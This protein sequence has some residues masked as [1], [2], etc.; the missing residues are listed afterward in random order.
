MS[1][2]A[3]DRPLEPATLDAQIAQADDLVVVDPARAEALA[4]AAAAQAERLHLPLQ[5][6]RAG[7]LL[8]A[9]LFFQARYAEALQAFGQALITAR[10]CGDA[11]LEARALNGLGNVVSHQ[12]DYAGALEY[13][14][15]SSQVAQASGDEQGRVRVLN[16]IAAVWAELGEHA[17]AL[18]AH[19][20]V[21]EVAARLGDRSLHSSAC[22]NMMV[23][24]NALGEHAQALALADTLLPRLL[25]SDMRQHAVVTQAYR[26]HSLLHTGQLE[27]AQTVIQDTLPLAEAIAEQVHVCLLLLMQ[28]LIHQRQGQAV[29]ALPPLERALALARE[30]GIG[31]QEQ[32][33]LKA[34]SEVREALGDLGGALA[35]LRAHHALER[36]IHAEA[37]DRKTRFLTAQFQLETL[38]REAEQER[39]RAQQ[40]QQDH[41]ALQEDHALLAHRAAHDPL[42]GLANRAHFQAAAE[43]ALQ[44]AGSAPVGLLF[45]DLDGFKA[46]ND[47]L[48]HDAGDDL[49][50]QVGARLRA[51]VRREDLVARP[52][53]DEFTVLLPG[54]RCPDDA[55]RVARELLRLITKPFTVQGETVQISA[56]VGVAVTPQ[57]GQAFATLQRRAD[58][59]MYRV[60][61]AGK[62]DVQGA[63]QAG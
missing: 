29:Q 28:G 8:G 27:A 45:L 11:P 33:A 36:R 23:D 43:Q 55:H 5:G 47:T 20:E 30:H 62:H 38:R 2:A 4:R 19:Q 34:L 56:S 12:G 42:T 60:K 61:R 50:R 1:R 10:Q 54:L 52:G 63:A 37:V 3:N 25:E 7:V 31:R 17:S 21:V 53:G 13:F 14:L 22:V 41:A 44:R 24:H 58:E 16:N 15:N 9:T 39:Q 46:V 59:A 32:D 48:G 35:D 18:E 6:G 51:G 49:L 57:D 40:L 26:A